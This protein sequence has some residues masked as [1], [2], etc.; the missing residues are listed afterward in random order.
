MVIGKF[1]GIN[2]WPSTAILFLVIFFGLAFRV[3][4]FSF[5]VLGDSR[6]GTDVAPVF[7]KIM[8]EVNLLHPDFV[9]HT[10]DWVGHPSREGWENFLKVMKI[11][12]VPFHLTIGNHET[13][14]NWRILYKEMIKKPFHYSFKHEKSYFIIL[15]CYE[16][17]H[18]KIDDK[19]FKWLQ[20]ELRKA[21]KSDFIFVF[22]HEPLY[23]VNVHIGSS[24]DRYPED[25][26]KLA[27]LLGTYKEKLIVFCGHEHVYN[28]SVIDG[29]QQIITGGAGAPLYA[30]PEEGGFF[31]YLYLTVKDKKVHIAV[32]K[33]GNV[34]SSDIRQES[35]P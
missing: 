32:I 5:V 6:N 11:G 25:R 12:E 1:K 29:L 27:N 28:K 23:P 33:P 19:Q 2:R 13:G 24:L 15:S 17:T 34:L 26:D 8:E 16:E 3:Y 14:E 4:G 10:G 7:K 31:H 18:G 9:V 22:V 35:I 21:R 20:K 30:Q